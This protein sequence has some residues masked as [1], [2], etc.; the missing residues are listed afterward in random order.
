MLAGS[1]QVSTGTK[2][3]LSFPRWTSIHASSSPRPARRAACFSSSQGAPPLH[4]GRPGEPACRSQRRGLRSRLHGAD[5]GAVLTAPHQPRQPV[6]VQAGEWSVQVD[7]E[8]GQAS[9]SYPSATC[10]ACCRPG[11]QPKPCALNPRVLVLGDL[12][13]PQL[14]RQFGVDP[15]KASDKFTVRDFRTDSLRE[16]KKIKLAWPGLNYGTAK[17]VLILSPS[18]RPAH[19]VSWS[20]PRIAQE[21]PNAS[22]VLPMEERTTF[23]GKAENPHPKGRPKPGKFRRG[24]PADA[25][26]ALHPARATGQRQSV[27]P[28]MPPVPQEGPL[29][30]PGATNAG[31]GTA[32]R[33]RALLRAA[34]F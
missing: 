15:A 28:E 24:P 8:S 30:R 11:S 32:E 6:S 9:T 1:V 25:V 10:P 29:T 7:L 5:D 26:R 21:R 33:L 31:R 4:P 20:S 18:R 22:R 27:V 14:Y 19:S 3:S 12:S 23:H 2:T 13:W 34:F 17:G 16:L